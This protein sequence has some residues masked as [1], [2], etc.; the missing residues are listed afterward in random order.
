[1]SSTGVK[2]LRRG[3]PPAGKVEAPR[4]PI[5]QLKQS[6]EESLRQFR[7]AVEQSPVSVVMTAPDGRIEYVNEAFERITGYAAKEVLGRTPAFLKSGL[8][9]EEFYRQLWMTLTA[10]R[11][12]RGE[13][14]NRRK[15]GSLYWESATISPVRDETGA[16]SRFIAVKEDITARKH[17]EAELARL[18]GLQAAILENAAYAIIAADPAGTITIFN[19]AAERLLG[20]RADEVVGRVTPAIFHDPE[21]VARRAV[22]FSE[23]LRERI[24]PGF[25]VF[26]ARARRGLPNEY[27]WTYLRKDGSR[28]PV[29]LSVTALWGREGEVTGYLGIANDIAERK[30][31]EREIAQS[32]AE[33]RGFIR[34]APSAVAMFDCDMRYL[35]CSERWIEDYNLGGIPVI[36]RS[37]YEV[38]PEIP[39]RWRQIHLR[40]LAGAVERS[41]EDLFER[42]DGSRFWLRWEVR[43]WRDSEGKIGGLIMASED[44]TRL[45]NSELALQAANQELEGAIRREALLTAAARDA[46]KAKSEFLANMSHEIRTPMNAVIG[47]SAL[48]LETPLTSEQRQ[49]L[50]AVQTSGESLL[51][52]INDILDFSKIEARRLEL[53]E[54]VFDLRKFV[55]DVAEVLLVPARAKGLVLETTVASNAPGEVRSDPTRL[56]QVLLNLG[57][58]A[59]KFTETGR[60]RIQVEFRGDKLHFAVIDTGIGIPQAAL[61]KLFH[62]F[63]QADSSTTRTHGGT[64][65]GLVICR[66]LVELMGGRIGVES[67][68]GQ[69]SRFWFTISSRLPSQGG[70]RSASLPS[71]PEVRAGLRI[72]LAEDNPINQKVALAMLR[73]FRCE[74][75]VAPNGEAAVEAVA[76]RPFD[77]VLMDCQMPVLDGYE[78]TARIRANPATAGIPI[79]A[80]TANA[81]VG[82][83]DRCLEAGMSDYLSKP[84]QPRV[85][86]EMLARW[87]QGA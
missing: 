65:L 7:L 52:I 80:M 60:I 34:Q 26:V 45:K 21:E 11:V 38:F 44:I 55:V 66:H 29:L 74:V 27:E 41:D 22:E 5:E 70:S 86:G 67:A 71:L 48:L 62:A 73:K 8:L 85:F 77:L 76:S 49:Y 3:Q 16:I 42:E 83:R 57:M 72:L 59:I 9:E 2:P 30:R 69:G 12:W 39:E 61:G 78:A 51:A 25:D 24:E 6:A 32:L 13:F 14:H 43:P 28:V 54:V 36:G 4:Q 47:M 17:S 1:M 64:G 31:G 20:Y 15:D 84:I 68:P 23:A 53:E 63:S 33:L 87:S 18:V 82:D 58:N 56:R 10:G 40:C 75:E 46:N 50:E 81:M 19:R 79:I 37:H 35:M